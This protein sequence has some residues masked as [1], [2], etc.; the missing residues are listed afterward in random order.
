MG[1]LGRLIREALLLGA[2]G[3]CLAPGLPADDDLERVRSLRASGDILALEAIV[4][5]LPDAA[6]SR[7]LEVELG[8]EGGLLIYE[9]ERLEPGGRVREYRINARTGELVGVEDD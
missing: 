5:S 4:E 8:E 3:L 9:I 7:I 6:V 1:T 2:L